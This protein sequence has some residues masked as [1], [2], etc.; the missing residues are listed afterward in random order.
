MSTTFK[1]AKTT[2]TTNLDAITSPYSL[3]FQAAP[4]DPKTVAEWPGC[5]LTSETEDAEDS[6]P[7]KI[8]PNRVLGYLNATVYTKYAADESP[9]DDLNDVSQAIKDKIKALSI[10]GPGFTVR[11]QSVRYG[12]NVENH[13]GAVICIL[14]VGAY[15]WFQ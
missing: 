13:W 5:F 12:Y 14:E 6:S 9:D 10:T 11:V 8:I 15:D 1:D 7:R 3:S 4:P 2:I